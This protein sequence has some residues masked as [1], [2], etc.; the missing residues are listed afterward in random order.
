MNT[1]TKDNLLLASAL[2]IYQK[3]NNME[4]VKEK[5]R[6]RLPDDIDLEEFMISLNSHINQKQL[7]SGRIMLIWGIAILGISYPATLAFNAWHINQIYILYS[8]VFCGTALII[9]GMSKIF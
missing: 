6:E 3:E 4:L 2:E 9:W 7:K 5:L 1:F 8:S